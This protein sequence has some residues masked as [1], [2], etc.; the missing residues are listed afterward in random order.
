MGKKYQ[1]KNMFCITA[2]LMLS[3]ILLVPYLTFGEDPIFEECY[4]AIKEKNGNIKSRHKIPVPASNYV[5][6]RNK[7]DNAILE[8]IE[9]VGKTKRKTQIPSVDVLEKYGDEITDIKEIKEKLRSHWDIAKKDIDASQKK[10]LKKQRIY[11][12]ES[13][14]SAVV[15]V[16]LE[17][18]L[19]TGF[20]I[21]ENGFIITNAHVM[22]GDKAI[23]R[24]INGLQKPATL[25][26]INNARDIALLKI[27]G[28]NYPVL[29]M[30][31][32]DD[33]LKG[34]N[35][36]AIG[37]PKGKEGTVSQGAIIEKKREH[38]GELGNYIVIN[39]PI[40][41]GNSGGPL[42]N[43]SMDIIGVTTG[44]IVIIKQSNGKLVETPTGENY[45]IPINDV[46]KFIEH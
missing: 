12:V 21:G 4:I 19:G 6:V 32:S 10:I 36:I 31:N 8:Y 37:S 30:G 38:P 35:V 17:K 2:C 34:E 33:C 28:K 16:L 41:P 46:K 40:A 22:Q 5:M 11:N 29:Q 45:S 18:G 26:K 14:K 25:V 24:F 27:D 43:T 9:F 15:T 44:G 39:A 23:V 20:I 42:L 3:L 7:N 1:A 13:A